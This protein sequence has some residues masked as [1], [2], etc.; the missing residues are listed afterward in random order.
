MMPDENKDEP[1]STDTPQA[2][3]D[4]GSE[5]NSSPQKNGEAREGQGPAGWLRGLLKGKSEASL[6]EAIEE[7]IEEMGEHGGGEESAH[8]HALITNV[9]KLRDMT[10]IDVMIPRADIIAIDVNTT[11]EDLLTLLSDKQFSRFPVFRE[12]LDDVLGT[13]HIKDI[14]ASIIKSG[15]EVKIQGLVRDVPIV[16]PAM[17]VHDLLLQMRQSRKHMVLV[18]DEFGGIDGLVTIGDLIE[19]IV[20]EIDDE[21]DQDIQAELVEKPDGSLQADARVDIEEFEEQYGQL[22]NEEER[23]DIDTLGGLVFSMAGRV[24]ARG[25]VLTHESGMVFEILDADPRR[26][27]SLRIRNIPP[28]EKTDS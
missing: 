12:T 28:L 8:E 19:A 23:E 3:G 20:G 21:F 26:V 10:V 24:P 6:R 18:V 22:L 5:Q 15:P 9:L 27:K 14:L 1:S 11:P 13:I 16:S 2:G 4:N 25:E 7:Y 17:P